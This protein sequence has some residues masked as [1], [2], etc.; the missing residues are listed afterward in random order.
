M[1]IGCFAE[2]IAGMKKISMPATGT[3]FELFHRA[4]G[5]SEAEVRSNA[6]F[7]SGLLVEYADIDLSPQYPHLL[8][9]LRPLFH[10]TAETPAAELNG[11]DNAAGAV[12][13]LILRNTSAVPLDHVLPVLMES[14]PLS[15]DF[16]ENRPLFRAFFHLFRT[17]PASLHPHMDRLL[18]LFAHVLD[19]NGQDQIGD[20]IRADLIALVNALHA[21]DP[22]KVQAAGLAVFVSGA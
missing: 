15:N 18:A 20:E 19:P 22:A 1:A 4:L 10:V 2:I 13:R 11:R 9:A 12:A 21:E 6:A 7:A 14:L 8:T 17:N 16:A 3:L 5:D